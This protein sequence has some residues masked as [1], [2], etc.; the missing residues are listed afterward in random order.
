MAF[1][2][3][4]GSD[5]VLV[6]VQGVVL[7]HHE[8]VLPAP[9]FVPVLLKEWGGFIGTGSA[10]ADCYV[11]LRCYAFYTRRTSKHGTAIAIA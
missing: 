4:F 2:Y 8:H 5:L 6:E 9:V 10:A 7:A 1:S 11:E 3:V